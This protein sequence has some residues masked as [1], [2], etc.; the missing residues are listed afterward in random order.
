IK[1]RLQHHPKENPH[2]KANENLQEA[3]IALLKL[4]KSCAIN[5]ILNLY[6][7]ANDYK[8]PEFAKHQIN[9]DLHNNQ[10]V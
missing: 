9:N 7:L 8:N 2:R 5:H 6:H 4:E 10:K 1:A 3:Q